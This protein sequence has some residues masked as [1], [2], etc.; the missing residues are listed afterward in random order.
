ME[1]KLNCEA[2]QTQS[3]VEQNKI[4]SRI[5]KSIKYRGATVQI[6][7]GKKHFAL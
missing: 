6:I 4:I 1:N 5:I 7:C 2:C 3:I